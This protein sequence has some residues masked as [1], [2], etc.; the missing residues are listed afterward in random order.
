MNR[1][2]KFRGKRSDDGKWIYGYLADE[3]Y[4]NNINEI[5]MPS[6]EVDA[7]TVG[8]FSGIK[9]ATGKEIYE[10]DIIV[11]KGEYELVVLWDEMGWALMPCEH[12][13]DK[14]FWVMNIQHPGMDWW[15]LFA[16]EIEVVGNIYDNPELLKRD[17]KCS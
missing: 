2:I 4:I 7:D 12:Y 16:N 14:I 15:K 8:Q 10:R 5:A 6:E 11:V 3:D 17:I 9:D 1:E 13:H